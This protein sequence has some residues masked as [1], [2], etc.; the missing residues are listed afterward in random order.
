MQTSVT[1]S[2]PGSLMLL[3][4]HA[5]LHGHRAIVAAIDKRVSVTVT[6]RADDKVQFDSALGTRNM[7]SDAIDDSPP[8]QFLATVV[9]RFVKR[10][11]NGFS[12]TVDSD[13]PPD[14][15]LGSS[16]AVTVAATAA[17]ETLLDESSDKLSLQD[18]CLEVIRHVQGTGA[19]ADAA[20]SIFGGAVQYRMKP[21]E[22]TSLGHLPPL[23][24]CYSGSKMPTPQVVRLVQKHRAADRERYDQL[25]FEADTLSAQAADAI[26]AEDWPTLGSVMDSGQA[27]MQSI[28][29]STN[30]LDTIVDALRQDNGIYGA[31]ISGSGLGDCVVGI[32]EF[33][34]NQCP[35]TRVAVTPSERGV[36][37]E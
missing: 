34:D 15:G 35:Y 4:E 17:L 9:S 16:A 18:S 29:V 11:N 1:A 14:F 27:I 25:Y 8:F 23:T 31:K 6:P 19:G 24:V 2:A 37:I 26:R 33:E 5:V 32:G 21:R 3:G 7:P 12:I 20:A 30:L 10:P 22:I 36:D 13:M 28:G